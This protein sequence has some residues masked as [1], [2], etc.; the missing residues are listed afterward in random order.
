MTA[1]V[2]GSGRIFTRGDVYW[3]A[4]YSAGVE[5]RES[6]G[7]RERDARALLTERLA[8]IGRG[9]PVMSEA[10]RL[11]VA[12]AV[13]HWYDML[14]EERRK[15]LQPA[16]S[17]KKVLSAHLGHFRIAQLTPDLIKTRY[18][19]ARRADGTADGTI[20]RELA[21]LTGALNRLRK[22]QRIT[23]VPYVPKPAA[24]APRQGYPEPEVLAKILPH[25]DGEVYRDALI[26]ADATA[27]RAGEII[28][29]LWT[30]V[31]L[32]DGEIRMGETKNGDP[33]T[34]PIEDS[35]AAVLERR[36]KDRRLDC[37]HVF[38]DQ[39][40]PLCPKT[41]IR[42]FQAACGAAETDVYLVHDLRRSGIRNLIRAGV[43]EHVAM[44]IS[45]HR[46]RGVF[47]RYN[48]TSIDDQR[49]ALRAAAHYRAARA[50][51]Q[52]TDRSGHP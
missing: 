13:E 20:R 4:Y 30:Q 31:F 28:G 15:G 29:L 34:I 3:I 42:R 43:S 6:A 17:T 48:V 38:H 10:G 35:V 33:L 21:S 5:H 44:S 9:V 26:Y 51:G 11:T 45:G 27:R 24:A 40:R 36:A 14:V 22:E 19:A 49:A 23:H 1:R 2:R 46:D 52:N 25:V 8:A 39:G 50:R 18:I 37:L 12:D 47:R 41:L 7:Y 16:R 32:R